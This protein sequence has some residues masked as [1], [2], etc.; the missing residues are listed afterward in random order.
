MKA[1]NAGKFRK[2]ARPIVG[3]GHNSRH[4]VEVRRQKQSG[5][6]MGRVYERVA[7]NA[8]NET[9]INIPSRYRIYDAKPLGNYNWP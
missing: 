6:D 9:S 3:I 4:G 1:T 5:A 2:L 8:K 7:E